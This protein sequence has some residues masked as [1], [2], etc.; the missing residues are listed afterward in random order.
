[1]DVRDFY[2]WERKGRVAN[3]RKKID[4]LGMTRLAMHGEESF[5][6]QVRDLMDQI[7]LWEYPKLTDE[8]VTTNWNSRMSELKAIVKRR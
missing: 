6:R 1:M 5:D 3:V 2:W 4:T 7:E 8:Q